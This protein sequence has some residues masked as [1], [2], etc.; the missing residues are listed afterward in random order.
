MTCHDLWGN[1]KAGVWFREFAGAC[2]EALLRQTFASWL[3][4]DGVLLYAV[5]KLLG[6][7]SIT[8]MKH[9]HNYYGRLC[10]VPVDPKLLDEEDIRY[11]CQTGPTGCWIAISVLL[12]K[13][14]AMMMK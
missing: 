13:A 2:P 7:S 8:V 5:Q 3:V 9:T 10:I 6:H 12:W 4:Q 14:G 11:F 1:A